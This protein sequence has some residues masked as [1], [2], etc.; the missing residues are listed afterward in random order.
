[1]RISDW[2]SDVCSSDLGAHRFG[3]RAGLTLVDDVDRLDLFAVAVAAA[4]NVQHRSLAA[5]A[6]VKF[7]CEGHLHVPSLV[8]GDVM[9]D[10]RTIVHAKRASFAFLQC[11]T[12]GSAV[13]D[14]LPKPAR[15]SIFR[16][17]TTQNGTPGTEPEG[18]A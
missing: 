1:M 8:D 18:V 2:S 15:M 9:C 6:C 13:R 11:R 4:H 16:R 3:D 12:H 5:G 10:Y 14:T 17:P 7:C